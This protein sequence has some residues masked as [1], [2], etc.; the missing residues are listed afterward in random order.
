MAKQEWIVSKD[1]AGKEKLILKDG[2]SLREYEFDESMHPRDDK[3]QFADGEGGGGKAESSSLSSGGG[4]KGDGS[5]WWG[6]KT[7]NKKDI[8]EQVST[9][10]SRINKPGQTE[11]RKQTLTK[12]RILLQHAVD[13]ATEE[14]LV[15]IQA[16]LPG[17]ASVLRWAQKDLDS[18]TK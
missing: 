14:Q 15:Q 13:R 16:A 1:A 7:M 4:P 2:E 5:S 6:G 3:G 12:D 18:K 17:R 11:E 8:S 10:T 9:L